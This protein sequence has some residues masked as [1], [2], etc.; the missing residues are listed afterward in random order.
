MDSDDDSQGL[1]GWVSPFGNLRVK[2]CL[3]THRSFS[4]LATSFVAYL[5]QGI[6]RMLFAT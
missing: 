2:V 1:P 3:T 5:H 4:Q 6:P